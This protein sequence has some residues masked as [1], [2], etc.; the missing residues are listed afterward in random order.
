MKNL[1]K[2]DDAV[3][4]LEQ[5]SRDLE[6]FVR[7]YKLISSLKEDIELSQ[8]KIIEHSNSFDEIAEKIQNVLDKHSESLLNMENKLLKKVR[9]LYD[10]NKKYQKELDDTINSK[11]EKN[12][13]DIEVAVRNEGTQIQRAFETSLKSNFG[14]M[15]QELDGKFE[16]QSKTVK[17]NTTF[18][19]VILIIQLVT[20]VMIYLN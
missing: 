2:L 11:L 19:I 5:Q 10:D 9:E 1:E 6:E 18:L 4:K 12:K 8:A 7:V 20:G 16:E 15:K 3:E 14:E 13:S 17:R